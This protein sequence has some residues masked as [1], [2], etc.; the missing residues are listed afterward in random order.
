MKPS[1]RAVL[2]MLRANPDGLCRRQ[3]AQRDV[4]E[5]SARILELQDEGAFIER[6][7]CKRHRH[8]VKVYRYKLVRDIPVGVL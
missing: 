8:R 2:E 7:Q 1:T 5:V 3:F 4:Y 6:G